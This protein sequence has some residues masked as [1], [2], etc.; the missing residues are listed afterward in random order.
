MALTVTTNPPAHIKTKTR[1][2]VWD[3]SFESFDCDKK[4]LNNKV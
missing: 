2:K 1:T 3:I 4:K